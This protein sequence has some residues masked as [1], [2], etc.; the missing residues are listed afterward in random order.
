MSDVAESTPAAPDAAEGA[1]SPDERLAYRGVFQRLFIRP[2]IGAMMG[3][4]GLWV[5][6]WAVSVPFGTAGG[7]AQLVDFASSP[8]GIMAV[9]VSMLM[10]GGEFDLSAGAMTGAMGILVI[11]LSL[12][13]GERGGAGL[14]LW[15]AIPLSLA[16]ALGVGYWN[17]FLVERTKLPSFII[18][19]GTFFILIGA[20]LGFSKLIVDQV[21][22]GDIRN[23]SG[24][25]FWRAIFASE[26]QRNDHQ[27][28]QRD[29]VFLVLIV[30]VMAL[31]ILATAEMQFARRRAGRSASGLPVFAIGAVAAI[32]G[33]AALHRTD[34]VGGNVLGAGLI[35]AGVVIGL[36]GFGRWRF[37]PID[38]RGSLAM[39][40]PVVKWLG[41]GV[42]GFPEG[43]PETPNRL[44]QM[45]HLKAKVDAGADY[46]CTQMFFDNAAFHDWAER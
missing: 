43:H 46:V 29:R 21:Q 18:T 7:T 26:W 28:G 12:E 23:A 42:A 6:F 27:W 35:A 38:D 30:A 9:A 40:A 17:G 4:L 3:V 34:S 11:L 10:V 13:V 1:A 37:E 45:D 20:K 14:N 44:T 32:V 15:I 22:V 19:L 31:A 5:F 39:P 25:D 2:E 16:F 8:L 24:Y 41:I 33:I 36:V